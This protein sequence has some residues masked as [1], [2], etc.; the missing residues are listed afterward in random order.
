MPF[1]KVRPAI[2]VYNA[3]KI[4]DK[5]TI[6]TQTWTPFFIYDKSRD[7]PPDPVTLNMDQ[8]KTSSIC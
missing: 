4:A 3:I 6:L 7:N 2:S 5:N 8:D 1:K